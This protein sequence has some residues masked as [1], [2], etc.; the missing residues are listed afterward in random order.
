MK[1][2]I[3]NTYGEKH[4]ICITFF[5]AS[6]KE[7]KTQDVTNFWACGCPDPAA[8]ISRGFP[9]RLSTPV[10]HSRPRS[11]SLFVLLKLT[12]CKKIVS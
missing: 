11:T 2:K 7:L 12:F 6:K 3:Q 4:M 1:K 8:A 9:V 10:T 5:I